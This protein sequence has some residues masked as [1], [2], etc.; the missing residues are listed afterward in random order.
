MKTKADL[1]KK[2]KEL[3]EQR[4]ISINKLAGM[5]GTSHRRIREIESGECGLGVDTLVKYAGAVG[6]EFE[7]R[8]AASNGSVPKPVPPP[9]QMIREGENPTSKKRKIVIEEID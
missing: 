4:N 2:L 5:I 1:V 6:V 3:R 8:A 7:F 9:T